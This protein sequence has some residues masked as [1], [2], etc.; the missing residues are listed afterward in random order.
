MSNPRLSI[1]VTTYNRPQLL[2]RSVESALAQTIN[3]LEVV[4]VDDGSAEPAKL[5]ECARLKTIRLPVNQGVA[6]ARNIGATAAQGR[7]IA[8]LDD[9]DQLLPHFAEVSLDALTRT[10]LPEPVA[11]ISGLEMI[12]K[13]GQLTRTHLPPTLPRGSHFGLEEI[14]R[15]HSFFSKQSLVV[16]RQVLL[17]IG[18]FD[19]SFTAFTYTELFL[20]LNSVCSILGLPVVTYRQFLHTGS[21]ISNDTARRQFNL[22]RLMSKHE[23]VF[24]AH[25]RMFATFACRHASMLYDLG[26]RR[27]AFLSLCRAAHLHPIQTA[28]FIRRRLRW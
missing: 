26:R 1:I 21:R 3:D 7:W 9:D 20:R 19:P 27:E 28:S 18:G 16:D 5:P 13:D 11:V 22:K 24:N 8:H 14:D 10:E 4:V 12:N 23:S 2:Q 15:R 17:A 6:A 25:R